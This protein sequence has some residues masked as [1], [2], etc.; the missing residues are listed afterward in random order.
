MAE[1]Y[2]VSMS[3]QINA[4]ARLARLSREQRLKAQDIIEASSESKAEVTLSDSNLEQPIDSVKVVDELMKQQGYLEGGNGKATWRITL[5]AD[6]SYSL[7]LN[8]SHQYQQE[9]IS[10]QAALIALKHDTIHFKAKHTTR[11]P[12]GGY[13]LDDLKTKQIAIKQAIAIMTTT[14]LDPEKSTIEVPTRVDPE[15]GKALD[16]R[17]MTAKEVLTEFDAQVLNS[18]RHSAY[19][20][21]KT[22]LLPFRGGRKESLYDALMRERQQ[23]DKA[24]HDIITRPAG[25]ERSKLDSPPKPSTSTTRA[26]Q[27]IK[28]TVAEGVKAKGVATDAEIQAEIDQQ[29][30]ASATGSMTK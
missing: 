29:K 21:P 16:S 28:K 2:Y 27:A 14:G 4:S 25:E 26:F 8:G 22:H 5:E 19:K 1:D 20:N 9:A 18:Q 11:S 3:R 7:K 17:K 13:Q 23:S 30:S 24:V 12:G 15:T 6:G 10:D